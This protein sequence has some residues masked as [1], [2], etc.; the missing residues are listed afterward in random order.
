MVAAFDA[1]DSWF[2]PGFKVRK[3]KAAKVSSGRKSSASHSGGARAGSVQ[4]ASAKAANIKSVIKKAPEVMVKITGASDGTRSF[5]AHIDY[6]SRNGKIE[7]ENET[8]DTLQG[9]ETLRGLRD[10]HKHLNVPYEGKNN[11]FLHVMFSM[12]NG[13]PEKELR[14]AVADFCKAEFSNRAYLMA[15]HSDTKSPHVHVCVGTRDLNAIDT[16]RLSPRKNDLQR[17]RQSFAE[18]LRS[19]GVD[20]AASG[21]AVRGNFR[22]GEHAAV[23]Q[24]RRD[25]PPRVPKVYEGMA[26]DAQAAVAANKRPTNPAQS[27]ID[28]TR[29]A[30]A[31]QWASVADKL[32][33]AGDRSLSA[34]A[35]R[36]VD[37]VGEVRSSALQDLYDAAKDAQREQQR[38]GAGGRDTDYS[39]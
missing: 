28:A 17:W 21:R 19:Q 11:E 39:L 15:F 13:T 32:A 5:K 12:P 2:E 24:Q 3:Q 23:N 1:I 34:A 37:S 4:S 18:N 16:P 27:K 20:A 8:G 29:A 33:A 9:V 22:K 31:A 30:V 25:T 38:G 14:K 7:L 36:M 26:K 35:R 10:M 6:I